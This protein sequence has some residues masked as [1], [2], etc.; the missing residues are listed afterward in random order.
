[1]SELQN[2]HNKG[3]SVQFAIDQEDLKARDQDF[4]YL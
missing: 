2:E 3:L 4:R 1:M